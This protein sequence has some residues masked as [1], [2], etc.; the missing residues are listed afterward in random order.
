MMRGLQAVFYLIP[1]IFTKTAYILSI[2]KS[3]PKV[4]EQLTTAML[5]QAYMKAYFPMSRHKEDDVIEWYQPEKRG[6]IP[7]DTFRASK[8]V[9]RLIQQGDYE[10]SMNTRFRDVIEACA[11]RE[12]TWISPSLIEAYTKLHEDGFAY[13][14]EIWQEGELVGGLYGVSIRR[15]FFGESMFH[16]RPEMDKLA[17]WYCHKFLVENEYLLWDTQF[18]T[19][20]L[21]QFGCIE[22]THEEYALRLAEALKA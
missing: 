3:C 18:Y 1:F 17:L 21:A 16:T 7:L 4:L 19:D 22:I 13:S 11:N 6:I 15:A 20:H 14:V 8:N 12:E 10:V 9:I 5:V 2:N